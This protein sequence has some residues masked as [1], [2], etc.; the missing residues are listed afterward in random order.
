MIW[1]TDLDERLSKHR[2]R[3]SSCLQHQCHDRCNNMSDSPENALI[4]I[5]RLHRPLPARSKATN[6]SQYQD[7][8]SPHHSWKAELKCKMTTSSA[9]VTDHEVLQ[10]SDSCI[11]TRVDAW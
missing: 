9:L 5:N 4:R 3:M 2:C 11:Q 10:L 7:Q 6:A 8:K 1:V